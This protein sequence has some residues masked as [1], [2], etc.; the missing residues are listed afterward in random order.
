[1]TTIKLKQ[2]SKM[3]SITEKLVCSK[4]YYSRRI[5][6][7][8]ETSISVTNTIYYRPLTDLWEG[9]VSLL[10]VCAQEGPHVTITHDALAHSFPQ[11]LAMAPGH[12][13]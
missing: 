1:M 9:N 5:K 6:T 3:K 2:K 8:L 13:T 4:D 7:N 11:P 12:Q 10:S